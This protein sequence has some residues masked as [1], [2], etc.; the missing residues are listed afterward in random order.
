MFLPTNRGID[1][2]KTGETS[3]L[4]QSPWYEE[5]RRRFFLW[6]VIRLSLP[7]ATGGVL[8]SQAMGLSF[9]F[10]K[11]TGNAQHCY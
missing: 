11:L 7:F 8:V 10:E 9:I 1:S 3:L 5:H 4:T 2:E 6:C